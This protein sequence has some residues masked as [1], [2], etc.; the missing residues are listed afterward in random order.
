[1]KLALS[2]QRAGPVRSERGGRVRTTTAAARCLRNVGIRD[3]YKSSAESAVLRV[4][5]NS[6]FAS[7]KHGEG[8]A[9]R[10]NSSSASQRV[11]R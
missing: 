3:L 8:L 1:M 9:V 10:G 11:G 7:G 6:L 2:P 5:T 4:S